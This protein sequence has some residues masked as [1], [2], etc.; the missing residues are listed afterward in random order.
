MS[1]VFD[2]DVKGVGKPDYSREVSSGRIRPGLTPHYGQR[3]KS[4]G[5]TF[6]IFNA[7]AHTAAV[8]ATI[9]TDATAFFTAINAMVGFVIVNVTDG[10]YGIIIANTQNTATVAAL[11]GG[12]TNQWNPGDVYNIPSPFSYVTGVLAPGASAHLIDSETGLEMPVSIPE[13]YTMTMISASYSYIQDAILLLFFDGALIANF[14]CPVAGN[15]FYIAEVVGHGTALLDPTGST[16]HTLDI[17]VTNI[18]GANLE[19]GGSAFGILEEVGSKSLPT[20]KTIKC[21]QCGYEK[22]VPQETIRWICPN[23]GELNLYYNLSRFR[24]A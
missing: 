5:R 4:F 13:G 15:V 8:N 14:G 17:I 11:I 1:P 16:A 7:G 23:C 12:T 6:S 22:T 18:G 21:K 19:G 24:G 9:M 3:L 10:S 20:T 2:V